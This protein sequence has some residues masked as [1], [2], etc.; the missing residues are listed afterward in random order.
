MKEDLCI[1]IYS[2]MKCI[3]VSEANIT[4]IFV[5]EEAIMRQRA[6]RPAHIPILNTQWFSYPI[7]TYSVLKET[8]QLYMWLY[9]CSV[10]W[11]MECLHQVCLYGERFTNVVLC[12]T[13]LESPFTY[14]YFS[15][16]LNIY[17]ACHL[18]FLLS[19]SAKHQFFCTKTYFPS[20]I[21]LPYSRSTYPSTWFHPLL[22]FMK[23]VTRWST[24][25]CSNV[26]HTRKM[27]YVET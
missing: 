3:D 22:S 20:F 24:Q 7:K 27:Q 11:M 19:R 10:I 13:I 23:L 18:F 25:R 17:K 9:C 1:A 14:A 26:T 4:S 21:L 8:S 16:A 12:L 6:G 5:A 15:F 2:S